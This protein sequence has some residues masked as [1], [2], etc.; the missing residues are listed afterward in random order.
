[1]T[2]DVTMHE[3]LMLLMKLMLFQIITIFCENDFICS[4]INLPDNVHLQLNNPS[5]SI[6]KFSVFFNSTDLKH[7]RL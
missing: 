2:C 6:S 7:K 3:M 4:F 1:V 5:V